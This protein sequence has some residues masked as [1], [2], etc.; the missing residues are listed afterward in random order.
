MSNSVFALSALGAARE[1][2]VAARYDL[3]LVTPH[4]SGTFVNDIS[5]LIDEVSVCITVRGQDIHPTPKPL[6]PMSRPWWRLVLALVLVAIITGA[7]LTIAVVW[8]YMAVHYNVN[9]M[10]SQ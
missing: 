5:G 3:T 1:K 8:A 4:V 10:V 9:W 7:M 2:L 6:L